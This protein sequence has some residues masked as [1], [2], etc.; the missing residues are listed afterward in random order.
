MEMNNCAQE[1][2]SL[3]RLRFEICSCSL[4]KAQKFIDEIWPE[5]KM[6]ACLICQESKD[7]EIRASFQEFANG[8]LSLDFVA[9]NL[10]HL[11][12][13]VSSSNEHIREFCKN[14]FY[15]LGSRQLFNQI[16]VLIEYLD[17]N[18]TLVNYY[19]EELLMKIEEPELITSF[20]FLHKVYK[21]GIF[22][23]KRVFRRMLIKVMRY[24]EPGDM[25]ENYELISQI[26]KTEK[27]KELAN[28]AIVA[29]LSMMRSSCD[30]G[31]IESHWRFLV[32]CRNSESEEICELTALVSL[33]Y[34]NIWSLGMLES[35][36]DYL[37]ELRHHT[38]NEIR[39]SSR[40]LALTIIETWSDPK[41]IFEKH[42]FLISCRESKF[43]SVRHRA[44]SLLDKI[45]AVMFFSNASKL[46]SLH[47]VSSP[48]V[49][50]TIKKILFKIPSDMYLGILED[51]F[52]T[53]MSRDFDQNSLGYQLATRIS[54]DAL[55]KRSD[56]IYTKCKLG[57]EET[58][59]LAE[60]LRSI[61]RS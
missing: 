15:R 21:S 35:E 46:I 44:K 17:S 3:T 30:Y 28:L 29:I 39:R 12:A 56:Y 41:M 20:K 16:D 47:A 61:I 52:E 2:A 8:K 38:H 60:E 19:A 45:P 26:A 36:I 18:F 31:E 54:R 51:L 42:E 57:S 22:D 14:Q 43:F 55:L 23:T 33:C 7:K 5:E 34:M 24:W 9:E 40:D 48:K 49:C 25:R 13:S 32:S 11:L 53:Q 50:G 4:A 10:K 37:T 58:S 27:D 6:I 59:D 1:S